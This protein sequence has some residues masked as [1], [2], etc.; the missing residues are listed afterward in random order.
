M[1]RDWKSGKV[2][3]ETSEKNSRP[4]PEAVVAAT[5]W[6]TPGHTPWHSTNNRGK[7]RENV[8]TE[9]EYRAMTAGNFGKLNPDWVEWLMGWPIGWTSLDH[10]PEENMATW[11]QG[12]AV[13]VNRVYGFSGESIGWWDTDPADDE[14]TSVPRL[15]PKAENRVNRLKAIG[16]GQVPAVAAIAWKLLSNQPH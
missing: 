3:K 4:L 16:N 5:T 9:E 6:P 7:I 15:V 1:N 12:M 14:N 2:S 8:G 13:T 11:V 10:L